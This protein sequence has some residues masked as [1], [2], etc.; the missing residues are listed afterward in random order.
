MTSH[1]LYNTQ[2]L[3]VDKNCRYSDHFIEYV[4]SNYIQ[5]F[6][7]QTNNLIT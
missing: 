5:F 7:A 2:I 3:P 6:S 1:D 4:D